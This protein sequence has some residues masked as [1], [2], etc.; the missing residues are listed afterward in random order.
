[1][2]LKVRFEKGDTID[3]SFFIGSS[4]IDGKTEE[5]VVRASHLLHPTLVNSIN[6]I[7]ASDATPEEK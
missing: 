3:Q 5:V 6:K 2:S 1:M 4:E 7:A